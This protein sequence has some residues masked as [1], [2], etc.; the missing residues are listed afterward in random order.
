LLSLAPI[1]TA[2]I[3]YSTIPKQVNIKL[4]TKGLFTS[5]PINQYNIS[6]FQQKLTKHGNVKKK[7]KPQNQP[8]TKHQ[9][10]TINPKRS[11]KKQST[12]QNQTQIWQRFWNYHNADLI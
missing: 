8:E 12:H 5:V 4:N 9:N 7:K 2:N 1:A 3:K 10:P 6:R 11:L